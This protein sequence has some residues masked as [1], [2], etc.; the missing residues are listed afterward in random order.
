MSA[1]KI[2]ERD[3]KIHKFLTI[4]DGLWGPHEILSDKIRILLIIL[5]NLAGN[6]S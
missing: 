1:Q 6:V 3:F 4:I 5:M 2:D